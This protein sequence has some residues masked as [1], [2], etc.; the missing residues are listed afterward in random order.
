MKRY[1]LILLLTLG[2]LAASAQGTPRT[3]EQDSLLARTRR[4]SQ[5][6]HRQMLDQ[7]GIS[8]LRPGVT[9]KAQAPNAA[10]YDAR[11]AIAYISSP[12]EGGA[13]LHRR[14]YGEVV[15]NIAAPNLY[16]WMAGDFLKYAGPL[17]WDDLPVDAHELIA[18]CAPR[19]VF[20]GVGA[21]GDN[22]A[23][24]KGMFMDAAEAGM[25]Y[26]LLGK[27]GVGTPTFPPVET[28]LIS[29]D[30]GFRQHSGGH[31]PAPNWPTFI[32]F[33]GKYF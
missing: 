3:P 9:N 14:N 10:N 15:E 31:T 23:D 32:R 16:H 19:P 12:G 4:A 6:D 20:I 26:G 2:A 22:W 25:V 33:A 30:L 17:H 21:E 24:A 7:L 11:F 1:P 29:G 18:L 27:K 13:K 28:T 8:E 5:A